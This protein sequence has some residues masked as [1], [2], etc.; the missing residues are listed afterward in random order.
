[1]GAVNLGTARILIVVALVAAG[2][3]V[4]ANGFEDEP[5][6][7][8]ASPSASAS[9]TEPGASPTSSET[10][11]PT[12]EPS[13]T[14]P[15]VTE[16]V[17]I[18]VLNGTSVPGLAAQAQD[19][20]KGEGYVAPTDPG[21]APQPGVEVTTVYYR[22]GDNAAQNKADATYISETFF[23]GSNVDKLG[24]TFDDIVVNSVTVAIVI[25]QDYA[26]SVAA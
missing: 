9:P 8:S 24:P 25:G 5:S 17:A 4:L 15:P 6:T 11:S 22:P 18:V 14:P 12:D 2:A 20:L 19:M 7:T 13:A 1:M 10:A 16:G 3:V 23:P 21:N 26:E